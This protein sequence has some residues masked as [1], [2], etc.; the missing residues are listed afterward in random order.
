MGGA[1][2]QTE[3]I[4]LGMKMYI[5][6]QVKLANS[7][8]KKRWLRGNM[9][10]EKKKKNETNSSMSVILGSNLQSFFMLS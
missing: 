10:K 6:R 8:Q 2:A 9:E 1:K 3:T 4:A 5:C 7:P